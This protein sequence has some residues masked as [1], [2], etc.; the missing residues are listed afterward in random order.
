MLITTSYSRSEMHTEI[1]A[2]YR[3]KHPE[4][5]KYFERARK[6]MPGGQTR[7][8]THYDPF[9]VILTHGKDGQ[10]FDAD[11]H[12]YIDV[13]N[14]YTSLIHGHTFAP[15]VS[16]VNALL[17]RGGVAFP[18][19][20]PHQI[21][22]AELLVARIHTAE[23]VRFTNSGSEA[24]SLAARIARHATGRSQIV[25]A[26]EG[27]HGAVPP[28]SETTEP[29]VT[30]VPFN[31]PVALEAAIS[32]QTAAI[33]LE[34]FQ[35]AAGVIPANPSYLMHAQQL[36]DRYGALFILDE[37]QSLRNSYYGVQD[38]LGITPDLTILGKIIGGGYPIGAVVGR[39]EPLLQTSPY[40]AGHLAHAGTFNG[41]LTSCVA[42]A[43]TLEYLD[44]QTIQCLNDR[45]KNLRTEILEA[46][47]DYG[48]DVDVSIAGSIMNVHPVDNTSH[49]ALYAN[50][51]LSLILEG[52]YAAPRGMLNL[53][54]ALD[55]SHLSGIAQAYR[56]AFERMATLTNSNTTDTTSRLA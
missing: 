6:V 5:A 37:V 33:I 45:A 15:V 22:L 2:E 56:R 17:E 36:A 35:G 21:R 1:V 20:H 53:S 47:T 27:Y 13:V 25:M 29:R 32:E 8:V 18:A 9:P 34:P 40:T 4:S 54:T 52:V 38:E 48:V 10:V 16:A 31:D 44:A 7:S 51:H 30:R 46:A 3:K 28:F 19:V 26:Q 12:E 11:G 24:S 14:N 23:L 49:A 55:Q 39:A 42:G 50:L 43:V 41:H